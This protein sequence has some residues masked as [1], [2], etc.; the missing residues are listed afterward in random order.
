MI[1]PPFDVVS[2]DDVQA[3]HARSPYNIA[4]VESS[5]GADDERF[6]RAGEALASWQAE[7]VLARDEHESY[8]AYE[9]RA[10]IQGARR[11]RRAFFARMRLY[12]PEER[13]VRPHE[14][15]MSGPKVERLHLMRATAANISP[16]FGLYRDDNGAASG[17]LARVA[18]TPPTFFA[19][20]SRGDEHRLWVV[21]E[22]TDV[23]TLTA[24]LE[25]SDVTIADGHHRYA[26]ALNYRDERDDEASGW[27]MTGLVAMDD[28]GLVI[29][30]N[31]RLVKAERLPSDLLE[32][33]APLYE[34][35]DITPK[36][37]DGTAVHRLWG[38]IQAH[39]GERPAFGMLG[40]GE[41]RLHVL[42][43]RSS[44]AI[45]RAMPPDWS[46][47]S[48]SL[49]VSILTQTILKPLLGIDEAALAA[50]ERVFFTEEVEEAWRR[51]EQS[52]NLLGFLVNPTRVEQVLAVA[53]ANELMP[54]KATFFYPKLGTGMVLNLVD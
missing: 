38:R 23:A 44:D 41:Q 49:D 50:G 47:A 39:A 26:T 33:L 25:A 2:E 10:T 6:V 42:V 8:Y 18:A 7:G 15:T 29:L 30:P 35:E 19:T 22:D 37:W 14:A 46:P 21:D 9:Q 43:A 11:T 12:Q 54:Q 51:V 13:V 52:H 27:V 5:R 40:Y 45:D 53:D 31:H 28:P 17:I 48:R 34:I 32:R 24:V 1:A 3:L 20:D 4:H 36:S 16:I